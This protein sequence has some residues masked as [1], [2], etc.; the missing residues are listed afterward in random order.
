MVKMMTIVHE[1]IDEIEILIDNAFY[2]NETKTDLEKIPG[3][4]ENLKNQIK[5]FREE[6]VKEMAYRH[7]GKSLRK[8]RKMMKPISIIT[9]VIKVFN[10]RS[11]S[12]F[13][14]KRMDISGILKGQKD[15]IKRL[16]DEYLNGE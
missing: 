6:Y 2:F 14:N 7:F 15:H 11:I 10:D 4:F 8:I 1:T 13:K 12:Y 16:R 3:I 9:D 5:I